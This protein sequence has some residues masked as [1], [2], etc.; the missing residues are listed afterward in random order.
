MLRSLLSGAV[1]LIGIAGL[2]ADLAQTAYDAARTV[3]IVITG[4]SA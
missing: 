4:P 2:G 1:L 3:T